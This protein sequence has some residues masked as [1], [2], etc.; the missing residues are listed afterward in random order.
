MKYNWKTMPDELKDK[1]IVTE[2]TLAT[3]MGTT[4]DDFIEVMRYQSEKIKRLESTL[5]QTT[6]ALEIVCDEIAA[7]DCCP[8]DREPEFEEFSE[9][10]TCIVN[11][12][13]GDF[14]YQDN[15]RDTACWI[16]HY[17]RK[18]EVTRHDERHNATCPD[19]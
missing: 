13:T 8:Y 12:P 5:T 14:V 3:H 16:R 7:D 17:M 1:A 10:A 4:K 11:N 6:K 9:C 2:L 19:P 18:A 15:D